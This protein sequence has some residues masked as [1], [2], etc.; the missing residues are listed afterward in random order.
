MDSASNIGSVNAWSS[1]SG[2]YTAGDLRQIQEMKN[3]NTHLQAMVAQL[4]STLDTTNSQLKTALTTAAT[5]TQLQ[6]ELTKLKIK[7]KDVTEEASKKQKQLTQQIVEITRRNEDE[8][9][10]LQQKIES[11]T[12]D[13]QKL[14]Q[15]YREMKKERDLLA[16]E[17]DDAKEQIRCTL[18]QTSKIAKQ[19]QKAK[20]QIIELSQQ[21]SDLNQKYNSLLVY[22]EQIAQE[23]KSR[24]S[25]IENLKDQ[26]TR[27][28]TEAIR[29]N[30]TCTTA[31]R[32]KDN[33]Q[34]ALDV[35]QEQMDSQKSELNELSDEREKFLLL[36]QKLHSLVC[37]YEEELETTKT[38]N[39]QLKDKSKKTISPNLFADQIN[40][41]AITF[42]FNDELKGR[43]KTIISYDHFQST[44][45]VQLIVN[46]IA[47]DMSKLN[48]KFTD[49]NSEDQQKA[50]SINDIK[51]RFQKIYDLLHSLQREWKNL[52]CNEN[53]I[54]VMAF[55]D[56]D[57]VF[58]NFVAEQSVKFNSIPNI[59]DVLGP[60]AVTTDIF[61]NEGE[62]KRKQL[63]NEVAENNKDLSSLISALFLINLRLKKQISLL[64]QS[65]G[66]KADINNVVKSLGVEQITD[67][68]SYI[69]ELQG[70]IEHL[71]STRKE[72]H[73]A[74]VAARDAI[75]TKEQE[76]DILNRQ[77]ADL[78]QRNADLSKE[79]D[80]LRNQLE[81][82]KTTQLSVVQKIAPSS[83]PT[84]LDSTSHLQSSQSSIDSVDDFQAALTNMQE[85]IQSKSR[86][87]LAL[88]EQ[89]AQLEQ[90][91]RQIQV[92]KANKYAKREQS[93]R[94]QI[95]DLEEALSE[96]SS[97]LSKT[98]KR[99]K[100]S[101]NQMKARQDAE[102]NQLTQ[103]FEKVKAD[104]QAELS[105]AKEKAEKAQAQINE[106]Q[107]SIAESEK[108]NKDLNDEKVKISR[109][110]Q[111][112][113]ASVNSAQEKY[114]RDQKSQQAAFSV[115]IL[116]I[117][118]QHQKE[119]KE[120]RLKYEAEKQKTLDYF[121][122]RL[123][124]I[125]GIAD[126]DS[127][128]SSLNQI[129]TRLQSDIGK[130]KFFQTQATKY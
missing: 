23:H 87:N 42:P 123:G 5:A 110:L 52:E 65:K 55:C 78:R 95:K 24:E 68:P 32:E 72:V 56:K 82:M 35:L 59:T 103:G 53:G 79:N 48:Q 100:S 19:K 6:E 12:R 77:L 70:K 113:E 51:A 3:Q 89:I 43:I 98:K 44:Q 37:V 2:S 127:D 118:T 125:Y 101:I 97:N 20:K 74:L 129:F 39:I 9:A 33:I 64:L 91:N 30:D 130:L 85:M 88:K 94:Q 124:A 38:Q 104:L 58:L 66:E 90:E 50:L 62:G 109:T 14:T 114:I 84:K 4:Q 71:K 47:K 28:K 40:L 96:T 18:E 36:I 76:A 107:D 121:T 15:N 41:E 49:L 99:A 93:L 45:K 83:P 73:V 128:E 108:K 16:E 46:E 106:L 111:S 29:L 67:V 21:I 10:E 81:K 61:S 102:F 80:T 13:L 69:Q 122:Q 115:K 112:L 27:M 117:E 86:E 54:D 17:V 11:Q 34:A 25:E 120:L 7:H 31:V 63:I 75:V 1:A 26:I 119:T 126:L 116:N 105:E 92:A 60:L 8:K 57:Q 22:H